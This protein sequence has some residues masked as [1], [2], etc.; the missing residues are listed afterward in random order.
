MFF[1]KHEK[2]L[3]GILLALICILVSVR[4]STTWDK[5]GFVDARYFVETSRL[6]LQGISPYT[7]ETN[8]TRY[9]YPMQAPSMSLLTMPLC[10]LPDLA[11]FLFF[12]FTGILAFVGFT[13]LIFDFY[14]FHPRDYLKPRWKNLPIWFVFALIL[15]SSPFLFSL[16]HGQNACMTVFFLFLALLYPKRDEKGNIIFLALSAAMKYSLLTMQAPVLLIQK[17]WRLC[18]FSF[19]LFLSMALVTGFWLDGVIP[20]IRDYLHLLIENTMRGANSYHNANSLFFVHIGFFTSKTAN[21]LA[22]VILL[23][24]Y[25]VTLRII[26]LRGKKDANAGTDGDGTPGVTALEWGAFAA[27]TMAI[28]YHRVYD[29]VLIVPFLGVVLLETL[30]RVYLEDDSRTFNLFWVLGIAGVFFLWT[31][32]LRL[33]YEIGSWIGCNIPAGQ[34]VFVYSNNP[35]KEHSAMFPICSLGMLATACFLFAM[36]MFHSSDFSTGKKPAQDHG[37]DPAGGSTD[38]MKA[39]AAPDN[40]E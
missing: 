22:K 38:A 19:L 37:G 23:V 10:P 13:V 5:K 17:R 34:A 26:H 39:E 11:V 21:T 16:R 28:S 6:I 29:A 33:F 2:I 32:P 25:G 35:M 24:L 1:K 14:G 40:P 27:L 18:V 8:P 4:I 7:P 9:K 12:F 20:S 31:F 30:K 3:A 15:T 36:E